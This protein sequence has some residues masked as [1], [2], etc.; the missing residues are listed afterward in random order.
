MSTQ[1]AG[2]TSD[3]QGVIAGFKQFLMR[4]NVMELAVAVV[5]GAAFTSIVNAVV[6]GVINPVVGVFGSKNL[7]RYHS[8]FSDVCTT[9]PEG[10]VTEGI[11]IL[12]GPVLS[13]TLTFVMTAA[14]VYFAMILPMNKLRERQAAKAPVEETPAEAT[15]IELLTQIRDELVAQRNGATPNRDGG[16]LPSQR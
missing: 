12:W 16:T 2:S 10:E 15:E 14:V 8:C 6:K 5:V 7:D 9:S 1:G 3:S 4:G 13:A 11:A